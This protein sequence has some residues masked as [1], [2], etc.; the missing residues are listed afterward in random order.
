MASFCSTKERDDNNEYSSIVRGDVPQQKATG[1]T[2]AQ[3]LGL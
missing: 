2:D 1:G 3:N